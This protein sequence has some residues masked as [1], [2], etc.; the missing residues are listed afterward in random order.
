VKTATF[1]AREV[2]CSFHGAYKAR[3]IFADIWSKCPVCSDEAEAR[4]DAERKSEERAL[5]ASKL[6]M[7]IQ[8]ACIPERFADRSFSSFSA[9]TESQRKALAFA[10]SYAEDFSSVL[11]T[12]RCG[13]FVGGVGTGKTHLAAAIASHVLR[14]GYSALFTTLQ[15]AIRRV[16]DTWG[17]GGRESEGDAVAALA[18]PDLLIIDEVGVQFGTDTERM[19]VFDILNTRYERRLPTLLLTN[20]D[21]GNVK[22]VLGERV[23]DRLREDGGKAIVFDWDSHRGGVARTRH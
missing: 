6:A 10:Q 14:Q 20:L 16:K 3:R 22:A 4:R 21:V 18:S 23:F 1:A 12:G 2:V 9:A 15:R 5:E 7:R 17:R 19:I 8:K 11:Q 13:L